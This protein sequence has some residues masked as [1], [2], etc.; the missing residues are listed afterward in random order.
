MKAAIR[1]DS[2]D[3]Y[4]P[5]SIKTIYREDNTLVIVTEEG[6]V[7]LFDPLEEFAETVMELL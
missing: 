6:V 5:F 3:I 7:W 2:K 4:E 1:I